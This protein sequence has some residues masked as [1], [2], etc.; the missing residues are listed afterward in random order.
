MPRPV[1]KVPA[2]PSLES[3]NRPTVLLVG[4]GEPMDAALRLALDRHTLAVEEVPGDVRTAVLT[5]AP[6][7]VLLVGDA[8]RDGGRKI[9][10]QLSGDASVA[11]IPV[12]VLGAGTK[13]DT[14]VA[15]Y[16]HGAVAVIPRTA[17]ADAI[18]TRVAILVREIQERAAA[19]QAELGEATFDELVDMVSRELRSGI[20][21]VQ[22]KDGEPM[23]V[24][25]GAGRPVAAAVEEFV[26]RLRPLVA[27][28]EPLNYELHVSSGGQ[29]G[30]LDA[31]PGPEV[32]PVALEGLRVLL[33]D[34]DPARAD[35][36]AQELR[37][38][39]VIV[40]V[41]DASGRGL[42][43]ARGLDPEIVILD[44]AGMEGPGFDVL[45]SIRRDVRLR[46]A[47]M[48]VAPWD[49]IWPDPESI[50]DIARLAERIAPLVVHDRQLE[51]RAASEEAFDTRLEATGPCRLFRILAETPQSFHVTFR[52]R[53][54]SVEVDIAEGL[55][56][57]AQGSSNNV[58]VEGIGALATILAMG[59]A[60]VHIERRANPATA[61]LMTPVDEAL[62]RATEE[63]KPLPL[64]QPPPAAPSVGPPGMRKRPFPAASEL[65]E[66]AAVPG[67]RAPTPAMPPGGRDERNRDES[68]A[69]QRSMATRLS[70]P[71]GTKGLSWTDSE[72]GP[73][74]A[75][76]A[77]VASP[78]S[79]SA[80]K[81]VFAALFDV[82]PPHEVG[83]SLATAPE[84]STAIYDSNELARLAQSSD[85]R[86][87]GPPGAARVAAPVVPSPGALG[88]TPAAG[89]PPPVVS[90]GPPPAVPPPAPAV[91]PPGA[92]GG[93]LPAT[94]GIPP[95]KQTL[96]M[97][98][99]LRAPAL[100]TTGVNAPVPSGAR[101]EPMARNTTLTMGSAPPAK[102]PLP[103][104]VETKGAALSAFGPLAR[105]ARGSSVPPRVD[106]AAS[107]EAAPVADGTLDEFAR[108]S[109]QELVGTG[110]SL[111][112]QWE[113]ALPLA[114]VSG[115]PPDKASEPL[116]P[117]VS[118][119]SML[120]VES[121]PPG[122][123]LSPGASGTSGEVDLSSTD[124]TSID[125]PSDTV[126]N[127]VP[128]PSRA[129]F[130]SAQGGH[131]PRD[132]G[133][134][135]TLPAGANAAPEMPREAAG[136]AASP[137]PTPPSP[138]V[139]A[140]ASDP[141]APIS[142]WPK[143]PVNDTIRTPSLEPTRPRR[144]RALA[145]V[146][147]GMGTLVLLGVGAMLVWSRVLGRALPW[148]SAPFVPPGGGTTTGPL[149][150]PAL[151]D[152]GSSAVVI[153]VDAPLAI[154]A[155]PSALASVDAGFDGGDAG[156][157]AGVDSGVDV[158][159]PTEPSE[160]PEPTEPIVVAGDDP[161]AQ[162]AELVTR[163]EDATDPVAETYYRQA[164][165][166]DPRNHYAMLGI[167][168]ILMRRGE[169][170]AAVPLIEGAIARRRNRA[171]YRVLLGDARRDAG[172]AAGARRAW[173]EAL[174]VDPENRAARSRLGL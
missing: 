142:A 44:A 118:Q 9:L 64:S 16:R 112:P 87:S 37:A 80:P 8:A 49:E 40:A 103:S 34:T 155:G 134:L 93:A 145:W 23:R 114:S 107:V 110:A 98:P 156:V 116:L 146:L 122:A 85:A 128:L 123:S 30:L 60:R 130:A 46:W 74:A 149:V 143:P 62:A 71:R 151:P 117:L 136:Q 95:R 39:K 163:A 79:G 132:I 15:A 26:R 45:R 125:E 104:N 172:D 121:L 139:P 53:N 106:P 126:T 61:N 77:K 144:S 84:E 67:V 89:S 73:K 135:A 42:E 124:L 137:L 115:A 154:D 165:A 141:T 52:S 159:G 140:L 10:D 27:R 43:R 17:S 59:S 119:D 90:P 111:P 162:A 12:A 164:L 32:E 120:A 96:V 102:V 11:A 56:V 25:L 58:V 28:A 138:V 129:A 55:V 72:E 148:E 109:M 4:R 127:A 166:L 54:G 100:P 65:K 31:E 92:L 78:Q 70:A 157:D 24:V 33:V 150:P 83:E 3:G 36:L 7:L 86:A 35:A 68:L 94:R 47:S 171:A 113:G 99:L 174:E 18:A 6:D 1:L 48:L 161:V 105:N 38:R 81:A 169:A 91:P 168:E 97:G 160:P 153:A 147:V 63:A 21:S 22:S 57:G 76:V 29:V 170:A 152:A 50:P 131:R 101:A 14:R 173:E 20:L 69:P 82:G 41:A 88:A 51:K 19:P 13:L 167:A 66:Q 108:A 158:G 2:K 75:N 133:M 5:M